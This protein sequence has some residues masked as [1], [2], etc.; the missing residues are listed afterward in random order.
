MDISCSRS[1]IINFKIRSANRHFSSLSNQLAM[2]NSLRSPRIIRTSHSLALP[3]SDFERLIAMLVAVQYERV[4]DAPEAQ[5]SAVEAHNEDVDVF[6][7]NSDAIS[8]QHHRT[9]IGESMCEENHHRKI[10]HMMNLI[11]N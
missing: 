6:H 10:A 3:Q 11:A 7:G 4:M 5:L 2:T 9:Q 1:C 8:S